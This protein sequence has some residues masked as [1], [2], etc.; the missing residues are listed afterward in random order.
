RP[1]HIACACALATAATLTGCTVLDL[2][3][4]PLPAPEDFDNTDL[5]IGIAIV[6]PAGAVM[7]APGVDTVV[8][9]ADIASV[10]GTVVRITAQR[11]NDL[12]EDDAEPIH[13]VGDGTPG[14]GRD[15]IADG[16]NDRVVWDITG[17]RVGDY[18]II[19]TIEA[20]DRSEEH[21]SE[22]QS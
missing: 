16:D 9:W 18:V 1:L 14:S 6:Q 2:V 5:N 21:T 3:F 17:V 15:A 10:D 12:D 13:L 19:A 22:L 11:R 7:A 4:G 8:Q 20:P